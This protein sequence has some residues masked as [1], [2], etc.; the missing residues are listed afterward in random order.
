MV[1]MEERSNNQEEAEV[2][3][4][5]VVVNHVGVDARI[6]IVMHQVEEERM[7]GTITIR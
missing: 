2:D 7:I 3:E 6:I 4:A 1:T 5:E